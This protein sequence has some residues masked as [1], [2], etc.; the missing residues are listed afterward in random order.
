[1]L[2]SKPVVCE[3]VFRQSVSGLIEKEKALME[4]L[5]RW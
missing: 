5:S 3:R 2:L 4:S 1:M